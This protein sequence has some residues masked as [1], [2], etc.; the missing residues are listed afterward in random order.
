[1]GLVQSVLIFLAASPCVLLSHLP[2]R[3]WLLSPESP[4]PNSQSCPL[5]SKL[6]LLY[7]EDLSILFMIHPLI[8]VGLKLGVSSLPLGHIPV[9]LPFLGQL[10]PAFTLASL[11]LFLAPSPSSSPSSFPS[12]PFHHPKLQAS[13]SVLQG[14]WVLFF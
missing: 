13:A 8:P 9:L 11:F 12:P 4:A 10:V 6:S 3:A 5:P 2:F 1:M 7:L 14:P